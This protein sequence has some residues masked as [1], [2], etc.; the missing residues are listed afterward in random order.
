[1]SGTT[2]EKRAKARAD[3]MAGTGECCG[4]WGACYGRKFYLA[5]LDDADAL[6][7]AQAE[8]AALRIERDTA[9]V[10]RDEAERLWK[11]DAAKLGKLQEGVEAYREIAKREG[12]SYRRKMM[13]CPRESIGREANYRSCAAFSSMGDRLREL[14]DKVEED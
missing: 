5:L 1:M 9:R 8:M 6:A 3:M 13:E 10:Q 12:E 14:L 4:E 2:K 7:S 11:A